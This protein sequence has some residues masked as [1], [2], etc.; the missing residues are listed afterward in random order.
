MLGALS[1]DDWARG[2]AWLAVLSAPLILCVALALLAPVVDQ[3]DV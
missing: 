3:D 1:V 2:Q